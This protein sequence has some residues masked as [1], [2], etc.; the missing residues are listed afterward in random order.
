MPYSAASARL[1]VDALAFRPAA[2]CYRRFRQPA[3]PARRVS[4]V[5]GPGSPAAH[6]HRASDVRRDPCKRAHGDRWAGTAHMSEERYR[7]LRGRGRAFGLAIACLIDHAAAIGTYEEQLA[8][9]PDAEIR[10]IMA[11]A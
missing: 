11:H 5:P 1:Q 3:D 2:I 6:H 8:S 9:E 7:K 10:T 4:R